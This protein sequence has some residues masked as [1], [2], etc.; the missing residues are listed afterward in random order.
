LA[1]YSISTPD[2]QTATWV[3][4][5]FD[6]IFVF[7]ITQLVGLFHDGVTWT[8]VGQA[9]LAFWLVW[10]AWGQFTW[11]LNA[12]DTKNSAVELITLLAG[13]VAFV[14][15]VTVPDAFGERAL[16]FAITYVVV[17]II[18]LV[19][20]I[21][22]SSKTDNQQSVAL[23]FAVLSLGGLG[24]VI[25]GAIAG[26]VA[27]YWFWGGAIVLDMFAAQL[28]AKSGDWRMQVEHFSERH[29]LFVIIALGESLIIAA[30]GLTGHEWTVELAIFSIGA[31]AMTFGL[32]WSYFAS[33]KDDLD[34]VIEE[35]DSRGVNVTELLR[36]VFSMIH[37]PMLLG[38]IGIA[39]AVEEGI[40][41][42]DHVL[43]L[44]AR[45]MLGIGM[46]LFVG[47][48]AL[49]VFRAGGGLQLRR[50]VIVLITALAV[51]FVEGTES[52]VPIL[53]ATAGLFVLAFAEKIGEKADIPEAAETAE[54]AEVA[55]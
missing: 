18:G 38:I 48:M 8:S 40:A 37:F 39:V 1:K 21:L 2:D 15:A 19:L 22:T 54:A 41:H 24:A 10:W 9:T 45:L 14:M 33:A 47:G 26:D 11:V 27:Q 29:G 17:R 49:A 43:E 50:L 51:I 30:H 42:P 28:G 23:T 35:K 46:I 6:L 13:A 16:W 34:R 53:I 20:S 44:E 7:S 25:A 4:L 5:F 31:L 12:A 36:D 32:W 52:Y 55:E 3:E